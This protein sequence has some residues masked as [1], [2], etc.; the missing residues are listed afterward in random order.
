MFHA[1]MSRTHNDIAKRLEMT[2]RA[3]EK[4]AAE[5]SRETGISANEW[6]QYINP[7]K[8]K[9]RITIDHV[10]L[11]KDAYG[12]TL[13]WIYDGDISTLSDRLAK[14]IRQRAAA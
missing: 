3:L 12:V 9:R 2:R 13:E 11:M 10:Y 14:K 8:Y 7:D 5:L 1:G 6:S 4:S